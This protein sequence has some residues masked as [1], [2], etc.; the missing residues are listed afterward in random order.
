[1]GILEHVV[2]QAAAAYDAQGKHGES[3]PF[4]TYSHP[5]MGMGVMGHRGQ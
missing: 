3:R 1:M 4:L 2:T 5:S